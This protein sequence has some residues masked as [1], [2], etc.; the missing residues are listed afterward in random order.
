MINLNNLWAYNTLLPEN[1]LW[2]E[3]Q[4]GHLRKVPLFV[5]DGKKNLEI[6]V[7]AQI[8]NQAQELNSKIIPKNVVMY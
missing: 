2:L 1:C 8:N 5:S 4:F 7:G 6:L 3:W